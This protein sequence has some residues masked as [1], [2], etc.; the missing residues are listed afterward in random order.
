MLYFRSRLTALIVVG[1]A[2]SALAIPVPL[3]SDTVLSNGSLPPHPDSI[4]SQVQELPAGARG[5]SIFDDNEKPDP[6]SELPVELYSHSGPN[7]GI[8]PKPEVNRSPAHVERRYEKPSINSSPVR[9]AS[10][11]TDSQAMEALGKM[12]EDKKEYFAVLLLSRWEAA[13]EE[14]KKCDRDWDKFSREKLAQEML[15]LDPGNAQL[16]IFIHAY[17]VHYLVVL[18]RVG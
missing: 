11:M 9:R 8:L 15:G 3:S 6:K 13:A 7:M 5:P 1:A 4:P 10:T 18:D 17:L 14:F 2:C 16:P 12:G